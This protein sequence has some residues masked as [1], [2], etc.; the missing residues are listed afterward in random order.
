MIELVTLSGDM[1]TFYFSQ[2]EFVRKPNEKDKDT[3][4]VYDALHNTW[5]KKYFEV[6]LKSGESFLFHGDDYNHIREELFEND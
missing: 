6:G 1:I 4:K 3:T 5:T 2:I